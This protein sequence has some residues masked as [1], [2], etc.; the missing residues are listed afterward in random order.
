MERI[1]PQDL[2]IFWIEII[3]FQR[4][5]YSNGGKLDYNEVIAND[6]KISLGRYYF[7]SEIALSAVPSDS[8]ITELAENY[9]KE[10]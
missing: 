3:F 4:K 6:I 10:I 5:F 7:T 9:Q 8:A 2:N 1:L